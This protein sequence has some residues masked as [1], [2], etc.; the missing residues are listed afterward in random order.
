[1]SGWIEG[2]VV[3]K[4]QWTDRLFS[5]RVAATG[6][7]FVAGQF[8]RLALPAP[9]GAK[10]PMLGRPYSFVNPPADAPHEFY[11]NVLP[12][13]PL[14]PRLAALEAGDPLW[15]LDRANG[16]FNVA[17]IPATS[18]LW[19][20]ATG[21]GL[22]PFLSILRTAEP[23]E[24]FERI[25]MVHAVRFAADL[26]YA[27]EIADIGHART[28]RFSFVPI[29]SREAHRGALAGRIPDAIGDGRLEAWTGVPL[30]AENAH[31]MLCGNPDMVRDTQAVL[32]HRG[33][34]RHRRRE[35]GHVTLETYW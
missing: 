21:T 15:L 5:L 6:P 19:C 4:R 2:Q 10:E 20:L 31:A 14:S 25:V 22:G 1:M 27:D 18:A 24:K 3:A 28:G 8:A 23:W 13:G 33:M 9:A 35:P 17:E 32:E 16:F 12:A 34:R 11:F 26:S 29:V 30:T 7:A